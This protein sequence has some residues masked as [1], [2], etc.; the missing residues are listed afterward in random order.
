MLRTREFGKYHAV[1][2]L[3]LNIFIPTLVKSACRNPCLT[4]CFNLISSCCVFRGV[5]PV[6]TYFTTCAHV[7]VYCSKTNQM[8][9]CG[10]YLSDSGVEWRTLRILYGYPDWKNVVRLTVSVWFDTLWLCAHSAWPVFS[11]KKASCKFSTDPQS[12]NVFTYKKKKVS[13]IFSYA[14]GRF[15]IFNVKCRTDLHALYARIRVYLESHTNHIVET[16][17][18][19]SMCARTFRNKNVKTR[20]S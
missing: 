16:R 4:E 20:R 14:F 2:R 17:T 6:Y 11:I 1:S 8:F 10:G 15:F 18:I 7:C 12:K 13:F 9:T 5:C 3:I 19:Q